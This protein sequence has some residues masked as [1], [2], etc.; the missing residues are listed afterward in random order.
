LVSVRIC[1]LVRGAVPF[2]TTSASE[3]SSCAS[4]SAPSV[5]FGTAS[6]SRL[7]VLCPTPT[8]SAIS[9]VL[10]PLAASSLTASRRSGISSLRG[11]G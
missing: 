9:R 5:S 11:A 10:W 8:T 3:S 6:K 1:A 2:G 7:T 4:D